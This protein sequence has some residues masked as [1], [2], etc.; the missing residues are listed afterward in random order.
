MDHTYLRYECA[1][2]F[3][4]T[5]DQALAT[6]S[7]SS[8]SVWTTAGS[9]IV[10][11]NTKTA[12]LQQKVAPPASD[13][14]VGTGQALTSEQV[15]CLTVSSS[16]TTTDSTTTDSTSMMAT[17]WN[18]GM[19]RLFSVQEHDTDDEKKVVHS[20]L[21]DSYDPTLESTWSEPLMV[22]QGHESAVQALAFLANGHTQLA[23]G[24]S[25]G[26]VVIWDVVA[27]TG[28]FR[29]I[30]HNGPIT[31]LAFWKE[32]H[33]LST[34]LDGLVKVWDLEGQ[35]CTQTIA[36]G[37][38]GQV[39]SA[40]LVEATAKDE[41]E[42]RWRFI[43]GSVNG[44]VRVWNVTP[45]TRLL[46]D[47]D[48][49]MQDDTAVDDTTKDDV[50][51]YMGSLV[52]PPNVVTPTNDRIAKVLHHDDG[53]YVGILHHNSKSIQIYAIRS[54]AD[55]QRKKQR[56]LRRRREKDNKG[57]NTG[58]GDDKEQEETGQKR[59]LMDDENKEDDNKEEVISDILES[60]LDV[61]TI[62][63][64]DEFEYFGMIRASHKI[65]DFGFLSGKGPVKV[66]CALST[67]ALET[68]ALVK[69]KPTSEAA[70]AA[71]TTMTSEKMSVLDMYGHA[72]GIRSVALSSDDAL[73][74]T[75]SKNTTKFW[76]VGRRSC[77]QSLSPQ[78]P[79][80][81]TASVYGLCVAFLPGNTHVILGTREGHLMIIDVASGDVVFCEENAHDGAIWS[82]DV[83]RSMDSEGTAIAVVTGSADKQVKFWDVEAQDDDDDENDDDASTS[84]H[85]MVVHTRTLQMS[86]DVVVVKYSHSPTKRLVFIS[87][88]DSTIKVFFDDSLK[89]FLS[90]YGHTLPALAVDASDDDYILASSGADKTIKIWGLDFGDT[91]RTLYGHEDSVTDLRFVK[92][93]HNF[94]TSSK[95]GTVRYWDGDRF[96]PILLLHGH[97]AEVN[98]LTVSRT[99]AFVLSGGMDRQVRVWE[100]T[101][102]IVFLEE[103]RE[104]ELEQMFDKVGD[105]QDE[106][107]GSILRKKQ[108]DDNEDDD[109]E[110]D[111]EQPQSAAAVRKSVISVS[112]GDRIMEALERAD[113]EMKDAAVFKRSEGGA[114]K[115]R[116]PNPLLLGLE[117]SQYVLWVL[118]TVKS[119][120]LE[121][122]LMV[123]SMRHMERLIYY[124]ITLLKAGRG[125]EICSRVA[126]F[127]ITAH[128]KQVRD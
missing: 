97:S 116:L 60:K 28:L 81:T 102:D 127:M 122:S 109:E 123:L 94:F 52:A 32:R 62:K 11:W 21:G 78:L 49:A 120:E 36:N 40:S 115:K 111:E 10:Q 124:L 69:K 50:C 55:A 47:D 44:Q 76:N 12:A 42:E 23:S 80:N 15:T 67:N 31:S 93:T 85:P 95:D 19:V 70:A 45:P 108:K 128:Q 38:D 48:E 119:A 87:T 105:R 118:R 41:E 98:C 33:L 26:A 86:D 58:A 17:G 79:D 5:V 106:A 90:L 121:Q 117:P 37:G 125:I 63:A 114:D 74:C 72:T 25:N 3:G 73:C 51:H 68:H 35:C 64:S 22:L 29:L 75:V 6:S 20:L 113:L 103:E 30:G 54:T 8:N 91:H 39:W 101:K 112:S 57:S 66:V 77:I 13:T 126:I 100:R 84:P 1:D 92:R 88:L 53:K 24:G 107:T 4:L 56:R 34:S 83:R 18:T 71:I 2:A 82:L 104:R 110:K 16:S 65:R 46:Q 43:T 59:G 7:T 14:S 99:G 61:D 27:E 9:Q 89:F 96:E